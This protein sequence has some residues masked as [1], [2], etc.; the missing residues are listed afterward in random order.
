MR[1]WMDV[2]GYYLLAVMC[3]GVILFSAVWTRHARTGEAPGTQVLSDGAQHL[4]EVTPAPAAPPACRPAEGAVLRGFS[5]T[6]VYFPETGLWRVHRAVDY[7]ASPG[8]PVRALMRGTVALAG[9]AVRVQHGDGSVSLYRGLDS[10]DVR[11]GQT[12]QA[13][14]TLGHAGRRV[15]FE[16][17]GCVCVSLLLNGEAVD[18]ERLLQTPEP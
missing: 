5:E 7:A 6:P 17:G 18:P 9:D 8:D 2:W 4:A 10:V 14:E 13:G 1:K 11:E 15:P 3:V 16:G 12:V